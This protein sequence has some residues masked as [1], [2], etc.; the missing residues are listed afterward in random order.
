M[1]N[2]LKFKLSF[3]LAIIIMIISIIGVGTITYLSFVQS[4]KIFAQNS[5]NLIEKNLDRYRL[6]LKD[7]ISSLKYNITM[8]AYNSSINGFLRAYINPYRYDEIEN[9]TYQQFEQEVKAIFTLMLKQNNSYFQIRVLDPKSGMELIKL[10]RI[11]GKIIT[12][13]EKNL[14][15]KI[16][17]DYVQ[18]ALQAGKDI[19]ISKIDLNKEYGK[20]EFPP[21]PTIRISK[22]IFFNNKRVGLVVINANVSTL[23]EFE[24]SRANKTIH[25]YIAN[26]NGYYLLN[27]REPFKEF[28]FEYG[29]EYKIYNDFPKLKQ[30]YETDKKSFL[31]YLKSPSHLLR[32]F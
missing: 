12:V 27:T 5:I 8:L 19:Y 26:K 18:E 23:L 16:N 2:E 28:G 29:K 14:Q 17:R 31:L 25:T 3:K 15:N 21:K 7:K 20:I 22:M 6:S 10:E 24:K 1:L 13:E 30:L 32:S 9:K 4:K 11:D